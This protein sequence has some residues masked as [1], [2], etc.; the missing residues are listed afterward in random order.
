MRPF[1]DPETGML[2]VPEPG[3]AE[4][5]A[6]WARERSG[7]RVALAGAVGGFIALSASLCSPA[8]SALAHRIALAAAAGDG[9]LICLAAWALGRLEKTP[10]PLRR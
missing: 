8:L 3:R 7:L 6:R 10:P 2:T 9:G 4:L 1:V 5:D